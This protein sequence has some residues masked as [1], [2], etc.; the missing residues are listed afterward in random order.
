MTKYQIFTIL[1][2]ISHI[3]KFR[4][5]SSI[6]ATFETNCFIPIN[7]MEGT[8]Q[9]YSFSFLPVATR[10]WRWKLL[11]HDANRCE[12]TTEFLLVKL[13]SSV[14][15]K[16]ILVETSMLTQRYPLEKTLQRVC[17]FW[18]GCWMCLTRD[19]WNLLLHLK[20]Y[21][22]ELDIFMTVVMNL[23]L[24]YMVCYLDFVCQTLLIHLTT[25]KLMYRYFP[26]YWENNH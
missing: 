1:P 7:F 4:N 21:L 15:W 2:Q 14:S 22:N 24:A 3:H 19:I 5:F 20:S 6:F 13:I 11:S 10:W 16:W 12:Y 23:R 26:E 8:C 9:E 17:V 25:Y 18:V